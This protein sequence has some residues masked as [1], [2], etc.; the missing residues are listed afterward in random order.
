MP[1]FR[2]RLAEEIGHFAQNLPADSRWSGV[3]R[4]PLV[5][6]SQRTAAVA[7]ALKDRKLAA[8][9]TQLT[10]ASSALS[11]AVTLAK[12]E[13]DY[14]D[15]TY[16]LRQL[17]GDMREITRSLADIEDEERDLLGRINAKTGAK[18]PR[19]WPSPRTCS[20]GPSR[21]RILWWA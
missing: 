21:R 19:N 14:L 13:I 6:A 9:D 3:L 11:D 18:I 15:A 10:A 5:K 4:R 7:T 1:S 17:A 16:T 2:R 8:L 12:R 20:A